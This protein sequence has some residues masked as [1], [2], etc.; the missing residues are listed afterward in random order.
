M[1]ID[2]LARV[3][4]VGQGEGA[5][6]GT[7]GVVAH[8]LNFVGDVGR[9]VHEGIFHIHVKRQVVAFHFPTR[10]HFYLVP[11]IGVG[12]VGI[13]IGCAGTLRGFGHKLELP[14]T[15]E[16]EIFRLLGREP[17]LLVIDIGTHGGGSGVRDISGVAVF[18]IILII[19]LVLPLGAHLF[20]HYGEAEAGSLGSGIGGSFEIGRAVLSEVVFRRTFQGIYI[21]Y[22]FQPADFREVIILVGV[23]GLNGVDERHAVAVEVAVEGEAAEARIDEHLALLAL[24][25][26]P[27]LRGGGDIRLFGI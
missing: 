12:I 8:A 20:G 7:H 18:L 15:V 5:A 9:V 19:R 16:R 1:Q 21:I 13:K 6:V 27:H 10:R 4:A 26:F 23:G 3:P 2:A 14:R 17:G 22:A 11:A 25:Q 24:L